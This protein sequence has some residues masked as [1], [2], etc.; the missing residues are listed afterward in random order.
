[1]EARSGEASAVTTDSRRVGACATE[2]VLTTTD[3]KPVARNDVG[4]PGV[5]RS[6]TTPSA[7]WLLPAVMVVVGC[8]GEVAIALAA[9]ITNSG[10][11]RESA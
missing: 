1:M 11:S 2:G 10:R 3:S 9:R 6:A 4:Q 8:M 5:G 7:S